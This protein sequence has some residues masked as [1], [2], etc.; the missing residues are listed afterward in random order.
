MRISLKSTVGRLRLLA[1]LEGI[2]LLLL[3]FVAVPLKYLFHYPDFVKA[4]GPIHGILFVLFIFS[5]INIGIA[6]RWSFKSTTWKVL[7]ACLIPFG[8]FYIDH[9]ILSKIAE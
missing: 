5:T 2:S 3:V 1:I 8:T 7:V 6:Q 4:L 9:R